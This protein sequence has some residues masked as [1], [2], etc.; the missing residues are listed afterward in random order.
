MIGL[1]STRLSFNT[2]NLLLHISGVEGG[3]S[4]TT[5]VRGTIVTIFTSFSF[6]SLIP[7]SPLSPVLSRLSSS[8]SSLIAAKLLFLAREM[9]NFYAREK[10][11][12]EELQRQREGE[13]HPLA[14]KIEPRYSVLSQQG[15]LITVVE[16]SHYSLLHGQSVSTIGI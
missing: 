15:F 13:R 11:G 3:A 1:C 8:S 9:G 6:P 5:I 4:Y 12:G 10:K 2:S 7:P 16:D 14:L